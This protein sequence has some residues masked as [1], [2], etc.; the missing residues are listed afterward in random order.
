[1]EMFMII[2]IGILGTI[3]GSFLNVVVYRTHRGTSLGGRSVCTHCNNQIP[4][5]FLIPILG[6]FLSGRACFHCKKPISTRYVWGEVL[7]G[8]L[9]SMVM[10]V[11]INQY[12]YT[13]SIII[14]LLYWLVMTSLL[15]LIS[16]YDY[17]YQLILPI[18]LYG[19]I[20]S[21]VVYGY[22]TGMS[23]FTMITGLCIVIPFALMYWYSQGTWIGFGDLELIAVTGISFGFMKGLG[24][25]V[26]AFW[27]ASVVM[28]IIGIY[29]MLK[30]KKIH[31]WNAVKK[32]KI[33]FGPFLCTSFLMVGLFSINVLEIFSL[34]IGRLLF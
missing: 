27:I 1:M 20:I 10:A 18:P 32:I 9:F 23:I 6:Y 8:V 25:V 17:L 34:W 33:P 30:N 2:T 14:P 16:Y 26:L 12:G 13:V 29:F 21:S 4:N 15:F 5:R 24:S 19:M 7:L 11:L 22:I 31:S 3:I 28:I